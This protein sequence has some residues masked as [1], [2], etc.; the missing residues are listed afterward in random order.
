[1]EQFIMSLGEIK[2]WLESTENK[3]SQLHSLSTSDKEKLLKVRKI[4]IVYLLL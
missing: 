3:L 4:R 1:M 2:G